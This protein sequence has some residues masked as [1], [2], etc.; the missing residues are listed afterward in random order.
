MNN[1]VS[2]YLGNPRFSSNGD[3]TWKQ[4]C[5]SV[6]K[7]ICSLWWSLTL[8]WAETVNPFAESSTKLISALF[9]YCSFHWWLGSSWEMMSKARF[10]FCGFYWQGF[11]AESWMWK[12]AKETTKC[13]VHQN[14]TKARSAK[15][16]ERFLLKCIL[17]SVCVLTLHPPL[18]WSYC[19]PLKDR[20]VIGKI[21]P[22]GIVKTNLSDK[23]ELIVNYNTLKSTEKNKKLAN[24]YSAYPKPLQPF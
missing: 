12:Y 24:S 5:L 16:R 18:E 23:T 20:V 21:K 9:K 4:C 13:L 11:F 2:H 10:L 15:K 17:V 14:H 7:V 1:F 19:C 8:R 6:L 22:D 3:I